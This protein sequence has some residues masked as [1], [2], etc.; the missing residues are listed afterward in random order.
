MKLGRKNCK[1]SC[2]ESKPARKLLHWK[3]GVDAITKLVMSEPNP[4]LKRLQAV[5]DIAANI[6]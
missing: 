2:S 5:F 3:P 6:D 1:K 4:D